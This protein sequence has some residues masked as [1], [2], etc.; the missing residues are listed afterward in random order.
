M[1]TKLLRSL[2]LPETADVTK[3]CMRVLSNRPLLSELLALVDPSFT[4][5]PCVENPRL[6]ILLQDCAPSVPTSQ[7][8]KA[9]SDGRWRGK[10]QR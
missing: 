6:A 2:S 9:F 5:D 3:T 8:S 1:G 7:A 10:E 4:V